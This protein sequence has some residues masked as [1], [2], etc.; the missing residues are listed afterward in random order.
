MDNFCVVIQGPSSHVDRLRHAFSS[1]PVIFS[2]WVGSEH[3]YKEDDIVVYNQYP[4]E[5]GIGNTNYQKATTLAGL[6]KAK[7][8]GC[9]R[10]L[11]IR[12]DM[13]PSNLS[14]F[15]NLLDKDKLTLFSWHF[16][17]DTK[18]RAYVVDYLMAGSIEDL[19]KMWSFEL[20][21]FD[22]PE[23]LLTNNIIKHFEG[24]EINYL[25]HKLSHDNEIIWIKYNTHLSDYK[26]IKTTS[27]FDE[28]N[29]ETRKDIP[30]IYRGLNL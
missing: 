16:V 8:R 30:S 12:S 11:K 19:I 17:P 6:A 9:T 29:W 10:A 23:A 14:D 7:E 3:H 20:R 15:M 28:L 24:R 21:Y 18:V 1:V 27:W 13:V 4:S 25:L 2:T 26:N 5:A 22:I